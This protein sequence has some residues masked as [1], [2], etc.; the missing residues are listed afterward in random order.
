LKFKIV[1][2]LLLSLSLFG[3]D[4]TIEIK[5]KVNT[6]PSIAI[7][8]AS[9]SYNDTFKIGFFKAL[10]ADLSVTSLFNV[11]KYRRT[12]YFN[13]T[14]VAVE[15]KDKNYVLRFKLY[16]DDDEKLNVA[17]KLLQKGEEKFSKK[18]KISKKEAYIFLSHA[19]AYDINK[20]V[21]GNDISWIK[22]KVIFA[23]MVTPKKSEIILSDY[24]L[25]YQHTIL[26][27]GFNNFSKMGKQK[28]R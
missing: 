9:I 20:F 4:L 24:T 25:T 26:K 19:I 12:T 15:N 8:D 11:D 1:I 5:K 3:Q 16:E 17:V 28:A 13:D 7:E 21:G 18:Y 23:K 22:K 10:Y 2:L 27:G 14:S 6:L